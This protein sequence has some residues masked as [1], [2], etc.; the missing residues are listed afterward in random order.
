MVQYNKQYLQFNLIFNFFKAFLMSQ[1]RLFLNYFEL[2]I[3]L[4][5]NFKV[6][7]PYLINR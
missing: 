2:I 6:L 5:L 7:N 4:I 1:N 3:F